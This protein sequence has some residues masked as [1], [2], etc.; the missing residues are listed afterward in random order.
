MAKVTLL[1]PTLNEIEGMKV[2]MPLIKRE[3]CDQI[4]VVDGGSKDGTIEYA[5]AAGYQVHVQRERGI[6]F[7]YREVL[8]MIEGDVLITFSPDGNSIPEAIPQLTAKMAEGYDMVIASR[9][10]KG[11]RSDD[12]D[13]VT[14]F[15]NWLFT[16]TVNMLHRARYTDV[17]V[18]YR[19]YRTQL[20]HDLE[21]DADRWYTTPEFLFRCRLSWEPMLSARAAQ[22]GLK[23][24]EIPAS[25]PP[26]IG[27]E[28]KLLV[29]Q[30]GASYYY[31]F[32][33]DWLFW[34]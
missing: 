34:Q 7:A 15:G 5:R 32:W 33:R 19:A 25:E 20:I 6:R 12:D 22:R 11:A 14:G 21:L 2:I 27:G 3:W 8:P 26:R 18:I 31:Q 10:A 30:W 17:M 16:G 13:A 1:V 23:I 4:I 28:R 24:T 29:W 9:Y